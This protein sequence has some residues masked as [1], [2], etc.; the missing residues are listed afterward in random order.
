MKWGRIA[1][2]LAAL[3]GVGGGVATWLLTAPRVAFDMAQA[4][5]LEQGGD[6]ARG[7][8]IFDAGDCASC[9]ASPGQPDR[10]R[11]GGG[12]A[13]SSPFGTFFPPNISP[14]PR[15]G[16]G[17][18]QTIDLANALMSGV[19]PDGQHYY[20]A[21]PYTS[22]AHI[23]V[24]DVRDLMAYLRMLPPVQGRTPQHDLAFPFTIRRMVG[25]WKLLYLDRTPIERDPA[26]DQAW[27]RGRYLVEAVT[28]CAEC[29]SARNLANAIRES[30][31]FAGGYDQ[32]G[33]GYVPNITP[34]GIGRWSRDDLVRMLTDG[35]TPELRQVGSSMADVVTNA[36]ALPLADR[37]AITTYILALPARHSPDAVKER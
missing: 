18:W 11:L 10:L 26:H 23:R 13:L 37:E 12:L 14:D 19:S 16:I 24:E 31:R 34:A 15:D 7:K 6:A 35:H 27:N 32:E 29:H 33:A 9:H 8:L 3:A 30:S 20:P 36:A 17:R 22:Y 1:A 4:A 5:A 28:H 25:F 21:L 2:V